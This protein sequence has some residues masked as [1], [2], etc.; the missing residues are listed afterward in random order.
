MGQEGYSSTD[1]EDI[2]WTAQNTI[3]KK[4]MER[5]NIEGY[6]EE[7]LRTKA[8]QISNEELKEEAAYKKELA[9]A[10]ITSSFEHQ[11]VAEKAKQI[12]AVDVEKYKANLAKE[13]KAQKTAYIKDLD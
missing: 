9:E 3:E 12:L 1:L 10:R 4:E 11:I 8:I 13:I 5:D 7:R 2:E 6:R